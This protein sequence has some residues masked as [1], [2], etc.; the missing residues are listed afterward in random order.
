VSTASYRNRARAEAFGA[1]ASDYDRYRPGYPA[2][3]IDDLVELGGRTAL[4]IGCGTGK[5]GRLLAARGLDVLGVE[6]D[7]KMAEVARG[8]GLPVEVAPFETWDDR[9]RRFDLIVSGQA[10]HWVDPVLAAPKAA[11]LLRPGGAV[12]LFWNYAEVD[13]PWRGVVE[14]VYA[15]A[16]PELEPL[17]APGTNRRD[18]R[19]YAKDLRATGAFGSVEVRRYPWRRTVP[20][21]DWV[22]EQ[23]THSNHLLLDPARLTA[24]LAALRAQ[25]AP[26]GDVRLTGGTYTILAR[27]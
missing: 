20:V 27:P 10:W 26:L 7:P 4:D 9:G 6:L 25:L 5:A 22:R 24:L 23:G 8:H 13:Q 14:Q 21:A 3:L 16:A 1:V 19:P 2:E 15:A 11:R 18:E 12:A 17:V